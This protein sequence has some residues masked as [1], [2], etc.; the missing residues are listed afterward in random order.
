[1]TMIAGTEKMLLWNDLDQGEKIKIYDK[2]IEIRKGEH[3]QKENLLVSY[4]AGDMYAPRIDQT[5]ALSL[6]VQEFADCIMEDRPPL[7]DGKSGL[8]VLRVLEAADR[9]IKADGA[10]VR[11]VYPEEIVPWSIAASPM[12]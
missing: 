2:G 4:R 1:M 11:I 5:E 8:R 3:E 7:T 9:S 10:N 12:M 6:V